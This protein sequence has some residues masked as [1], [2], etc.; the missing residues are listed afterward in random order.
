MGRAAA[1]PRICPYGLY[2]DDD[3]NKFW[4]FNTHFDHKGEQARK[5]SASLIIDQ[6][7][8]INDEQYPVVLM[9]DFNAT[10]TDDPIKVIGNNLDTITGGTESLLSGPIGTYN[11]FEQIQQDR[12]ID[13]IFT[14]GFHVES[15][16]H[17]NPK[18]GQGQFLS[19]H[20]PVI[21]Q[22]IIH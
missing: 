21:V 5:Q 10:P 12:R 19:D 16:L 7:N 15:Y 3:G 13:F 2:E 14:R 18:S 1:L 8:T 11:G 9:G 4:V 22:A 6:I 20:L 17:A